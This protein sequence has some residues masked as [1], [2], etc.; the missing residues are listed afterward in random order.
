MPNGF[1]GNCRA[2]IV[3]HV[4][5]RFS[6]AAYYPATFAING[7]VDDPR[8]NAT[9]TYADNDSVTRPADAIYPGAAS[10][11]GVVDT[12]LHDFDELSPDHVKSSISKCR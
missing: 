2:Q 1:G 8:D 12:L 7:P 11:H 10:H 3:E 9:T 4:P 6:S 5:N